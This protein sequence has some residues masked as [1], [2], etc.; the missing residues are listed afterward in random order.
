MFELDIM[1]FFPESINDN[2][3]FSKKISI[4]KNENLTF[5]NPIIDTSIEFW[6]P[7]AE[8]VG[9][10]SKVSKVDFVIIKLLKSI[11]KFIK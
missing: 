8:I 9:S 7:N 6:Q 5:A 10:N 2:L 3:V 4:S 1:Q 11:L